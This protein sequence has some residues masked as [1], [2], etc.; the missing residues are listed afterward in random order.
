M[1]WGVGRQAEAQ[2]TGR[3]PG[4]SLQGCCWDPLRSHKDASQC[5][6]PRTHLSLLPE[7]P[8]SARLPAHLVP[9][10]TL[11]ISEPHVTGSLSWLLKHVYR[12]WW[13]KLRGTSRNFK[14]WDSLYQNSTVKV[15]KQVTL[16]TPLLVY[17]SYGRPMAVC[18]GILRHDF[19]SVI[20]LLMDSEFLF[21]F[22][23]GCCCC[24]ASAGV[25]TPDPVLATPSFICNTAFSFISH[26]L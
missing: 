16:R 25:W 15:F 12:L 19:L 4:A 6:R 10:R 3:E 9:T 21:L 14:F 17:H 5:S 1:E 2:H 13:T 7:P 11:L 24:C 20:S 18:L 26:P 8:A 22:I 23:W